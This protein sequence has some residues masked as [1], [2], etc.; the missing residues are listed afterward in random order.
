VR[1]HGLGAVERAGQVHAQVALPERGLL[2]GELADV[3]QRGSV[4]DQDVDRAELLDHA[5]HGRVHLRAVGHV[6][7]QGE[8]AAAER[9]DLLGGRLGVHEPL[10]TRDRRE[11]AVAVGLVR[12]RLG[13]DEQVGD[14]NV[15]AGPSQR[16]RVR[17]PEPA[18]AAGDERDA[19]GEVDLERHA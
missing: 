9:T 3:I 13:L 2:V 11:H 14:R 17:P 15:R 1:P 5:R 8:R 16:E 7:A 19:A 4:I 18:R 10:R 6:A 12:A